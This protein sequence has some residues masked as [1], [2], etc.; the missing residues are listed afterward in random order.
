[1]KG[2][3]YVLYNFDSL[4]SGNMFIVIQNLLGTED[5][6]EKKRVDKV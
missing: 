6:D 4:F 2:V 5:G 1:M 3:G